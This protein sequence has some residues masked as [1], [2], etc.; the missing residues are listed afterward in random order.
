M[1]MRTIASRA[2]HGAKDQYLIR[3]V[4]NR[5]PTACGKP[6]WGIGEGLGHLHGRLFL[7]RGCVHFYH[8]ACLISISYFSSNA[9]T[10]ANGYIKASADMCATKR[11]RMFSPL[12]PGSVQ[13][14]IGSHMGQYNRI[15]NQRPARCRCSC[16]PDHHYLE[17]NRGIVAYR[18]LACRILVSVL[19]ILAR[20]PIR[21][22]ACDHREADCVWDLL[23]RTMPSP[24]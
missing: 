11:R 18:V 23:E 21:A 5:F 7:D 13:I 12:P 2:G 20:I 6:V 9:P 22:G 4:C 17:C 10:P 24:R 19:V 3:M 15:C 14:N 1:S 16:G 8:A